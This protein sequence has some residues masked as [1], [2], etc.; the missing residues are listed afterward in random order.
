[1]TNF[2]KHTESIPL[3]IISNSPSII[4]DELAALQQRTTVVKKTT[5]ISIAY[6]LY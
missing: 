4:K 1:V 3:L 5:E 6:T 2:Q